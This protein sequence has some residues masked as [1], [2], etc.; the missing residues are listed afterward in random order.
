[1]IKKLA[2]LVITLVLLS[3]AQLTYA[4]TED[5]I[6]DVA[7]EFICNCG[8]TWLLPNCDMQCGINLKGII[9]KKI[10]AGWNRQKI[11]DYMMKN[12]N[13]QILSAPTKKGFNITAWVTPFIAIALGGLAISLVVIA[14]VKST[15]GAAPIIPTK[16][17]EQPAKKEPKIDEE[18]K[19][20]LDDELKDFDW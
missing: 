15:S 10:D 12:Y 5:Q 1:M 11:V 19:K 17:S 3:G 4:A 14:W 2:V 7:K 20:K 6:N 9:S 8:C 13:E 18:Y 16:K